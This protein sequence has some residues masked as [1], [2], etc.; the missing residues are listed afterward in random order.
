MSIP[1]FLLDWLNNDHTCK[2]DNS[3]PPYMSKNPSSWMYDTQKECCKE[4]YG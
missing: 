3:Q 4:R 2:N 1:I